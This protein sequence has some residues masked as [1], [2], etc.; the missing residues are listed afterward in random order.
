MENQQENPLIKMIRKEAVVDIKIGSAML[1]LLHES[2]MLLTKDR[3]SEDLE[4]FKSEIQKFD[5]TTL[6][7]SF[8]ED[9][10]SILMTLSIL[11]RE[12]ENKAEEQNLTEEVPLNDLIKRFE[13]ANKEENQ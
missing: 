3:S 9:W 1:E 2:L 5:T 4:K 12:V 8:S 13:E 6:Q 7:G 11:V 10:M